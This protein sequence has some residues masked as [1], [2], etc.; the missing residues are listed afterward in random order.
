[1]NFICEFNR[2]QLRYN[3][4]FLARFRARCEYAILRNLAVYRAMLTN[5][6]GLFCIP[7]ASLRETPRD[8]RIRPRPRC[9][10]TSRRVSCRTGLIHARRERGRRGG[11]RNTVERVLARSRAHFHPGPAS[12]ATTSHGSA[13]HWLRE[14]WLETRRFTDPST[15]AEL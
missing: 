5:T 3:A 4:P 9:R 6:S 7:L 13:Y 11:E 1:M 15:K 12:L 2:A 10:A 8:N 14:L